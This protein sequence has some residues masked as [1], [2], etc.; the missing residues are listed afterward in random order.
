MDLVTVTLLYAIAGH[1]HSITKKVGEKICEQFPGSVI[2]AKPIH[3]GCDDL[4][5]DE[6]KTTKEGAAQS[7]FRKRVEPFCSPNDDGTSVVGVI[8]L[9]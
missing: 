7:K 3:S 2:V 9:K 6:V 8:C 4:S 1:S 5:L